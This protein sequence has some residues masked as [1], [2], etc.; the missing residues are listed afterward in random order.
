MIMT[1][2]IT[3]MTTTATAITTTTATATDRPLVSSEHHLSVFIQLSA[4]DMPMFC[5][6]MYI[7]L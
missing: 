2:I 5:F 1:T 7:L 3:I 6:S 4:L